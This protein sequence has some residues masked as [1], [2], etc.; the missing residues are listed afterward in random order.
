M[1]P[2]LRGP[3]SCGSWSGRIRT[4]AC[5]MF[6]QSTHLKTYTPWNEH[7]T[8]Q[9]GF[10]EKERIVFQ[11][12]IVRCYIS[13]REGTL[14][15]PSQIKTKKSVASNVA[16]FPF[17][18]T[19]FFPEPPPSQTPNT[20]QNREKCFPKN[21]LER[22]ERF[23]GW[24]KNLQ[25]IQATQ[26][27]QEAFPTPPV[28]ARLGSPLASP[29]RPTAAPEELTGISKG[30]F[31]TFRELSGGWLGVRSGSFLKDLYKIS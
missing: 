22:L 11:P 14:S 3:G 18:P 8:W 26:Y 27:L 30:F 20:Q 25:L 13:F 29:R 1:Q 21:W 7:S 15:T 2:R 5:R 12:S 23:Q 17:L 16:S 31:L 4:A 19:F 9:D 24:N 6:N 10:F 28:L